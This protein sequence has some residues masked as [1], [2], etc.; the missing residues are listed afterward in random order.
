MKS[1]SGLRA[2]SGSRGNSASCPS[3]RS[4]VRTR[5]GSCAYFDAAGWC[6]S[7]FGSVTVRRYNSNSRRY[8]RSTAHRAIP[9]DLNSAEPGRVVDT[10]LPTEQAVLA[11]RAAPGCCP[12]C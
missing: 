4:S 10:V 9:V 7:F 3:T 8:V 1:V 12:S 5:S 11:R 6:S 2:P